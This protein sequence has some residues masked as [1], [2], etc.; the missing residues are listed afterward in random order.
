M[1]DGW[2]GVR[3]L[4]PSPATEVTGISQGVSLLGSDQDGRE[5]M[6]VDGILATNICS[7]QMSC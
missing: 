6:K 5:H 2:L 1:K 4:D 7:G 3:A